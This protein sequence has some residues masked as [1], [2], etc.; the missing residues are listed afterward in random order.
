MSLTMSMFGLAIG[1]I[2]VGPI[3]NKYGRRRLLIILLIAYIMATI[4]CVL[5]PNI[6]TKNVVR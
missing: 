1:Q 6:H 4:L 3:S 2:I 5:S